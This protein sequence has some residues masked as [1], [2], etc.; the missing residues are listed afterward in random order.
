MN[1]VAFFQSAQNRNRVFDIRLA[2]KHNLEAAFERCIFFDVLA[3]LVER[4]C[5]DGAQFA[6]S[7]SRLQHIGGVDGA[8]RRAGAN[9]GM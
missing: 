2:D 3:I 4:G 1:F 8:F 7:Q 9:Q 5:A 6:T